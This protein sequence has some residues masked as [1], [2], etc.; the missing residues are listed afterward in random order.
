M[1]KIKNLFYSK[2]NRLFSIWRLLRLL[3]ITIPLVILANHLFGLLK[4]KFSFNPIAKLIFIAS[5]ILVTIF[6]DKENINDLG[7]VLKIKSVLFLICGIIWA[8]FCY[9]QIEMMGVFIFK[10]TFKL[11]NPLS[12]DTLLSLGYYILFIGLSEELMFRSY[13]ISNFRRDTN[14]VIALIISAI[15]F[16]LIHLGSRENVINIFLMGFV[17]TMFLGLIFIMT[18]NIF[19]AVGFHGAWDTFEKLFHQLLKSANINTYIPLIIILINIF[20]FYLIFK[21]KLNFHIKTLIKHSP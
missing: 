12:K 10:A 9:V 11:A 17:F 19:L 8:Y 18:K 1:I 21:R 15:L 14:L 5:I 2:Q 16:S 13:L 7:I 4:L 6:L 20:V 3:L